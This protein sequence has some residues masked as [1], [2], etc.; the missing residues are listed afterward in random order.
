M[1]DEPLRL[2][3]AFAA[4]AVLGT[5]YLFALWATVRRV[6]TAPHPSLLL[7]GSAALRIVPLLAGWYWIADGRW[8]GLVAC[9]LG[10]IGARVVVTRLVGRETR[11][12]MKTS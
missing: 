1:I 7:L 5:V 2:S 6:T 12:R 3:V 11:N 4:G 10:F 8:D 9:L